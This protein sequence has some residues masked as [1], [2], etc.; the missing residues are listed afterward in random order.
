[1]YHVTKMEGFVVQHFSTR[2]QRFEYIRCPISLYPTAIS[3]SHPTRPFARQLNEKE[4][5]A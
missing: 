1:M 4:V 3:S 5:Y 2:N